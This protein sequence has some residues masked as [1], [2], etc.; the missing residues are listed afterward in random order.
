MISPKSAKRRRIAVVIGKYGYVGGSERFAM[1]ITERLSRNKDF[2][3]HVL[4]NKWRSDSSRITFH[5]VPMVRFPMFLRHLSFAWFAKRIIEKGAFDVVHSHVRLFGAN[6]YSLHYVPHS[7][8]VRDVRKKHASL[9]DLAMIATEHRMIATG[10]ASWF[11]PVSSMVEAEFRREYQT[12]PG[13]WRPVHPGVDSVRFAAPDRE[14]CRAEIRGRY[15]IG[16][17]DLLVLFVGMNFEVKGL[18]TVIAAVANARKARP[19]AGIRLLVSGRGNE[20]KYRAIARSLGVEQAVTF[21]GEITGAIER[22]YRAADLFVMLSR[23]DTFGM[24]VLEAMAAGLPVLVSSRVGAKDIV[25]EGLN[26]FVLPDAGDGESAAKRIVE[27]LDPELRQAMAAGAMQTA[28]EHDWDR[29]ASCIGEMI[30]SI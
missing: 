13:H 23:Y 9:P 15:G 11:L 4:A 21:A 16:A 2:D 8:W 17:A 24:V 30:T 25:E 18:D 19:E 7:G 28:A 3:V 29:P 22:Y 10:E 27:L 14:A 20:G 12:L 5:K 26:G 6:L 1:E